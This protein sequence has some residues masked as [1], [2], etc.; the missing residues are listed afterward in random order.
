CR[1]SR[2][3][4]PCSTARSPLQRG[5]GRPSRSRRGRLA[6]CMRSPR[7]GARRAV[8]RSAPARRLALPVRARSQLRS[9]SRPPSPVRACQST[10]TCNEAITGI[11]DALELQPDAPGGAVTLVSARALRYQRG[12]RN[13]VW[14]MVL[15]AVTS[16][17]VGCGASSHAVEARAARYRGDQL[18]LFG[19]A[20]A[21]TEAKYPLAE[22]DETTLRIATTGRWYTPDGLGAAERGSDMRDVPDRSV[23]MKLI[24]KLVA[25]GSDWAVSVEP[26]MM[27][28]FAGRPNPDQLTPDDPSVPGWATGRVD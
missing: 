25:D 3:F 21:V 26:V 27:R 1:A 11:G 8:E 9:H 15:L 23:H 4:A 12:M 10:P 7:S 19:A 2:S 18:V 6:R 5:R 28:Y 16:G 24:V 22:S 14:S 20:K 13:L 17:A